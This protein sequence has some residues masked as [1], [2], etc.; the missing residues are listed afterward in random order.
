MERLA[1]RLG[2]DAVGRILRRVNLAAKDKRRGLAGTHRNER[3]RRDLQFFLSSEVFPNPIEQAV[4]DFEPRDVVRGAAGEKAVVLDAV[5]VGGFF[6]QVIQTV[7]AGERNE[8]AHKIGAQARAGDIHAPFAD[9]V[10]R[11]DGLGP[12]QLVRAE[13]LDI[14]ARAGHAKAVLGERDGDERDQS[15]DHAAGLVGEIRRHQAGGEQA[16][17]YE[18]DQPAFFGAGQDV[19]VRQR[20]RLRPPQ[21]FEQVLLQDLLAGGVVVGPRPA[22]GI[23]VRHQ[24]QLVFRA[25]RHGEDVV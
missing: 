6:E 8:G 25:P 4:V 5:Q 3:R 20:R 14:D 18:P 24:H 23:E 22:P 16:L 21:V 10:H 12:R 1:Q 9:R 13:A 15:F 19:G 2:I 17:R 11:N 7:V